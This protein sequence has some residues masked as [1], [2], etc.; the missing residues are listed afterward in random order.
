MAS[1]RICSAGMFPR[2]GSLIM[3]AFCLLGLRHLVIT[4]RN[5]LTNIEFRP[6]N[7]NGVA[8]DGRYIRILLI[9]GAYHRCVR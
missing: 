8:L 4:I 3:V 2:S 9:V 5:I 1:A 6:V 7:C